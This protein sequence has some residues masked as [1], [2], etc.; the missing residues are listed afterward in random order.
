MDSA[1]FTK[2]EVS[3]QREEYYRRLKGKGAVP[4]WDVLADLIPHAPR[5]AAIAALWRYDEM[6][7]LL[8]EAGGVITPEEAER[9]VLALENPG[10]P[11][12]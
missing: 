8:F 4:L 9:R 3:A 5:P 1:L 12:S 6:R 11:G 2:P 7:P 10:L